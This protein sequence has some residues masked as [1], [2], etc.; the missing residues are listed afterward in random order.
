M[1]SPKGKGDF[2]PRARVG[3]KRPPPGL[4]EEA[5][6]DEENWWSRLGR[7]SLRLLP[8]SERLVNRVHLGT[9]E[10]GVTT[11]YYREEKRFNIPA[12]SYMVKEWR[13]RN[14]C[15]SGV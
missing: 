3:V 7:D 11:L 10:P 12:Y 8:A 15:I 6:D 2:V 1:D 13:K 9:Q 5:D 14:K 4:G